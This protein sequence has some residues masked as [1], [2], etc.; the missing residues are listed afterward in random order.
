MKK[1]L[2]GIFL[3]ILSVF[4]LP[5][6]QIVSAETANT[7]INI[8]TLYPNGVLDYHNLDNISQM[9]VNDEYI[10]YTLDNSSIKIFNKDTRQVIEVD[11]FTNITE[12]KYTKNN[13]LL[14]VDYDT[15][16][17]TH[18]F[19]VVT[20]STSNTPIVSTLDSI[21][22]SRLKLIDIYENDTTIYIGLLN[23][24]DSG[25]D[26]FELYTMPSASEL[27]PNKDTGKTKS[28]S[29]YNTAE[30]L[31]INDSSQYVVY[32]NDSSSRLLVSSHEE[33]SIDSS[34]TAEM[35]GGINI[36]SLK[37]FNDTIHEYLF[38]F[39][40]ENLHILAI[41]NTL[42]YTTATKTFSNRDLNLDKFTDIDIFEENIII[43]DADKKFIKTIALN[44]DNQENISIASNNIL[45]GCSDSSL[46]RFNNVSNIFIQGDSYYLS[47]TKN[48]RIQII[49]NL[50][51][52][53][54]TGLETDS[55]PRNVIL[56]NNQN[57]YFTTK[58]P[59]FDNSYIFKY[60]QE[61]HTY[62]KLQTYSIYNESTVLGLVSDITI[63]NYSTLYLIEYSSDYS[64]S[65]LLS[66]TSAGLQLISSLPFTT[67]ENTKIDYLKSKNQLVIYSDN[68]LYLMNTTGSIVSSVEVGEC[69]DISTDFSNIYALSSNTLKYITVIDNAM[70]ISNN[71]LSSDEFSN[72]NCISYD[73]INS[74]MFAFNSHTQSIN[75]FSCAMIENPF[76]FTSIKNSTPLNSSTAPFA[77]N[78]IE[79]GLIYDSPYY[80]GNYYSDISN[81]IGIESYEDFYRVLFNHDNTLN[82]GF[83]HKD[84]ATIITHNTTKKIRVIT[85]NPQVPVYKY[86]TLLKENNQTITT[87]RLSI[88]TYIN[89]TYNSFPVSIDGQQFYL[90]ENNGELGYIFN[91][92]I[93]LDDTTNIVYLNT[94]NATISAIGQDTIN[95]YDE[96]KTT[97][98]ATLSNDTRIYVDNYDKN[99]QYTKVIYKDAD[100]NTIEGYVK[101]NY[102]EMDKLDDSKIVLI[103]IIVFS[104]IMLGVIVTSYII[105][106]R[107]K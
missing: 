52:Y 65:N 7:E 35:L 75:Y 11:N 37:Y 67:S 40:D 14:V 106:R 25:N 27:I 56:D 63:D 13:Q 17:T 95:I 5:I 4:T 107:K 41:S 18:S 101:T 1:Y 87:T 61:N 50:D 74:Q 28:C 24:S 49:D 92:D 32:K 81:C 22:L 48:N 38:A 85:T 89:V 29:F 55:N 69:Q 58:N 53:A 99:S 70:Q 31:V 47:D 8:N 73:I 26:Y 100:L 33:L 105:V 57:I 76:D 43:G 96:D 64:K 90:Y 84:Y 104:I 3:L 39:T 21:D 68:M 60:S 72:F 97:V 78:V 2:L 77:I 12:L 93:V 79:G 23:D 66:L 86:P 59:N 9:T 10:A 98:L 46:G 80:L 62:S 54:I 103:L 71:C 45:L 30:R 36:K 42:D 44:L 19:K 51:C 94:E 6:T 91:A 16:L 34:M 88:N 15:S 102:I 20:L 83:I 82:I